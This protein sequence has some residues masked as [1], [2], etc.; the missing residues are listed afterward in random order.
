MMKI[1]LVNVSDV[2]EAMR[3]RLL[4]WRNSSLVS[5]FFLLDRVTEDQHRAWLERSIRGED[6]LA[7]VICADQVPLGLVYLP[8]FDRNARR[9]EIGIY[10]YDRGFMELRPASAAYAGMMEMAAAELGLERL[11]ARILED[12]AASIRFHERMGFARVPEEDGECEKNGERKRVLM[13][14]KTL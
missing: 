7:C 10:L 1:R 11:Y 6:A 14:V 8:W 9:G 5:P 2:D 12:N 4:V 13:Y 3:S